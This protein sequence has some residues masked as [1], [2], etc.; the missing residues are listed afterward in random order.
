MAPQCIRQVYTLRAKAGCGVVVHSGKSSGFVHTCRD[1]IVY[2]VVKN[3]ENREIVTK[4][5]VLVQ[6]NNGRNNSSIKIYE[7]PLHRGSQHGS[8]AFRKKKLNLK[9]IKR[10]I[11]MAHCIKMTNNQ[12]AGALGGHSG[13]KEA[14]NNTWLF[15]GR[16]TS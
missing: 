2:N 12:P 5:H 16:L 4:M 7:S 13:A 6:R 14:Q 9:Y 8:P 1:I 3:C 10:Y 11:F 15:E